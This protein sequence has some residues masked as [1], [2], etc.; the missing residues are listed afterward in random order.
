VKRWAQAE[1][2]YNENIRPADYADVMVS[3]F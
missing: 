3:G 1:E 2:W